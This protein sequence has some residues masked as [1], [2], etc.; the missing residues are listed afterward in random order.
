M[1][2][3]FYFEALW[4]LRSVTNYRKVD[5]EKHMAD[6][7]I[8]AGWYPD[9]TGDL[10]KIRYWDGTAWTE[11]VQPAVTPESQNSA[12]G[13]APYTAGG[14]PATLQPIYAPGQ[15]VPV[16]ATSSQSNGREGMAVGREGMAVAS[17]IL[18]IL[19]IPCCVVYIGGLFGVLAIIFGCLGLKSSKRGMAI[20]G[21]ICGVV[22]VLLLAFILIVVVALYPDMLANPEEYGLPSD[23]F[24]DYI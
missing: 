22:G 15:T 12:V 23:Y 9:P 8:P 18:G 17:L 5:E 20:A 13:T 11:H 16:Y 2:R 1:M 4:W 10:S 14:A 24:E 19:S 21:I 7:Q 6:E 3:V